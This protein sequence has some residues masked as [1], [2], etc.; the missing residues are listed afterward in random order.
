MSTTGGVSKEQGHTLL[1][2]LLLAA[3][4]FAAV[5]FFLLNQKNSED[6]Q[7]IALT[8][9][10]QVLSQQT[11]KFALESAD[12]NVDSFKELESTRNAI[13]SAVQRLIKGDAA[14]DVRGYG[15]VTTTPTGRSAAAL[16]SSWTQLDA[17]I[18]KILSN[19]S[20]VLDSAERASTLSQQIP[21]L[22]SSMEQV[23]NILQQRNGSSEQMLG[24]S[25]QMLSADRIIRRVQE[26]LQGGSGAQ[27][28]ADGLSRDA[29]LYGTV[30]KGLLEG[31]S[32]SG[33]KP[34]GDANARKILTDMDT[35]W[36]QL[37]EPLSKLV[38]AAGNIADVKHAGNQASLD[39]QTVLLQTSLSRE[40]LFE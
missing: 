25:R 17:D 7:A 20:V 22:N 34:I 3:I 33:V 37:S 40:V 10:I 14:N 36:E 6:R 2:V 11:A 9:Q 21:L 26:V 13:D 5:D 30:L 18:G 1:I 16:G 19:R 38:G 8:T 23:V 35:S 27:S 12:G 4:G 24:T 32:Q 15:A 28:A 29:Q 31:N 39:S